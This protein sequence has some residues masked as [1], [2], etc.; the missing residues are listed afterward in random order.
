MLDLVICV[1]GCDTIVKY[2]KEILKIQET[3]GRKAA[4]YESVKVLFFLGEESTDLMGD[5]YVHIEGVKNDY[6]SASYKQFYGLKYIY[7]NYPCKFVFCCGTDTYI[8][9]PLLLKYSTVFRHD[10][11]LYIGGHGAETQLG[12]KKVYFHSG[13]AGFLLS[14]ASQTAL[15]PLLGDI[16]PQWM[17]LCAGASAHH[18]LPACDVTMAYHMQRLDAFVFKQTDSVFMGC[19]YRGLAHGHIQ[20]HVGAIQWNTLISCHS[21]SSVDFDDFTAVLEENGYYV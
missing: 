9:I 10:T 12:E 17:E 3:W 11:K 4:A 8:N 2:K 6:Q 13:G 1:Y 18:L 7:E 15:Y 16:V 20:C 14:H 21:M 5:Q 19:N